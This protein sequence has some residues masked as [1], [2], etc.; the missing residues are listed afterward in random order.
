MVSAAISSFPTLVEYSLAIAVFQSHLELLE[1]PLE[2]WFFVHIGLIK[3]R[4]VDYNPRPLS[5]EKARD[6]GFFYTLLNMGM[7]SWLT[8]LVLIY[9]RP[10]IWTS[11]PCLLNKVQEYELSPYLRRTGQVTGFVPQL[12]NRGQVSR[13][14][15]IC[16]IEAR[17]LDLSPSAQ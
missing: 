4:K 1:P 2:T 17:Y 14:V 11:I 5:A 9:K 13:F 12:I 3:T 10:G 7:G 6:S 16:S 15:P 8:T